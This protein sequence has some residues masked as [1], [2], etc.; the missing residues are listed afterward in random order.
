[1]PVDPGQVNLGELKVKALFTCA[2]GVAVGD[3]VYQTGASPE[4]DVADG[5]LVAKMPAIGLV[6]SKPSYTSCW[7][8]T[9]G[10]VVKTMWGLTVKETYFVGPG[11]GVVRASGLPTG[12]GAVI[13]ELGYAKSTD[14]LFAQVDRDYN[15][16]S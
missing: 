6:E 1:M 14:T 10:T 16:I 15:V 2:P 3:P 9:N 11:G 12:S 13:Q 8:V 7:V 5:S 4:V